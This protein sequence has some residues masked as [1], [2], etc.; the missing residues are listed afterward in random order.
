MYN[1][2]RYNDTLFPPKKQFTPGF[3]P[4][5]GQTGEEP[6]GVVR[7]MT[8]TDPSHER[9]VMIFPDN[10]VVPRGGEYF[11]VPSISTLRDRIAKISTLSSGGEDDDALD[12]TL[13]R[14]EN[15][16]LKNL[17]NED[18]SATERRAHRTRKAQ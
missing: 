8:G 6:K 12:G 9:R 17:G 4:I 10:F 5:V 1:H 11:F 14:L 13:I 16:S 15:A 7:F 2:D 3:D 18:L